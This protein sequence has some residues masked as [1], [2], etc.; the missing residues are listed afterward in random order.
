MDTKRD[1]AVYITHWN[2]TVEMRCI[3]KTD[4]DCIVLTQDEARTL[5]GLLLQAASIAETW[6][7]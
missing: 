7:E 2:D 3:F 6:R 1:D 4:R 5:A